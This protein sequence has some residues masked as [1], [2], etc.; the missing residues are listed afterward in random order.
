[1]GR[2]GDSLTAVSSLGV[3]LSLCLTSYCYWDNPKQLL[4]YGF[5]VFLVFAL[6]VAVRHVWFRMSGPLK[7]S[8]ANRKEESGRYC[9]I[10][11][12]PEPRI[13]FSFFNK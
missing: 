5:S 12:C 2:S 8:F 6:L 4:R 7:A 1:M 11:V 13:Y 10:E 9:H 3:L